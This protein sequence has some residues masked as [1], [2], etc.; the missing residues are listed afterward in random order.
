MVDEN[1]YYTL[2]T[3]IKDVRISSR[4]KAHAEGMESPTTMEK[5]DREY[6]KTLA[7]ALIGLLSVL[8]IV[9]TVVVLL[10]CRKLQRATVIKQPDEG[11]MGMYFVSIVCSCRS[12][13]CSN[14]LELGDFAVQISIS[15]IWKYGLNNSLFQFFLKWVYY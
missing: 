6:W 3:E 10:A 11:D 4:R 1:D 7:I 12:K 14:F 2:N 5:E 15:H 9:A 13:M 8:I